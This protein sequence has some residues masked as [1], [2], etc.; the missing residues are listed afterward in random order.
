MQ[1]AVQNNIASI[2]AKNPI[3]PVVTINKLEEIDGIV[4]ALLEK[5][6]HCIEVTLR[7]AIAFEAIQVIK[8]KYASELSVGVG[9]VISSA[10]IQKAKQVGVD[11]IVS[12]GISKELAQ[13]LMDSKIPFI[14]GVATPSD[15]ILGLQMGWNFFK[16]F[17]ANLFGGLPALKTYQLV[18]PNVV[19][20]PTGGINEAT[21]PDYLALENVQSVGGS[22]MIK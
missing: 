15:I 21:Y 13:E 11:F 22:W 19:F 8:E 5:N 2:L 16:F 3:I 9:T 20:C 12:P 10:Q 14:P 6:I 4:H 18:F 1:T 17:P 7:T